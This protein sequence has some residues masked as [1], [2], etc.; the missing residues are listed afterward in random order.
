MSDS[1]SLIRS[2]IIYGIVLPLAIFLGYMLVDLPDMGRSSMVVVGLISAILCAPFLLRWH[3][4]LLFLSW[5]M[6]ALVFFLPGSPEFWIFMALTSF[7]ITITHRALDSNV[8]MFPVPSVIWPLFFILAVVLGTA[9]LTGGI[10]LNSLGGNDV[11]GGRRYL[12]MIAAVLGFLA[13]TSHPIPLAKAPLFAGGFLLGN[14]TNLISNLAPYLGSVIPILFYIFPAD[15]NTFG[16]ISADSSSGDGIARNYGLSYSLCWAFLYVL[17]RYGIKQLLSSGNLKKLT[18]AVL[19]FVGGLV[20][21]F[22]S[23]LLMMLIT[24]FFLFWIEGLFRSRYMLLVMGAFAATLLLLPFAK[25]LPLPIQRAMTVLP[26]VEVD[27]AV[28]REAEGSSEWRIRM[29]KTLL[30][31]VPKYLWLGKGLGINAAEYW[32]EVNLSK[33][34]RGG[35]DAITFMMAGD[36]HNGPLSVIIPFGIWGVLG[37]FWFLAAA[38]RLLYLNQRH[39]DPAL[40]TINR[41]LFAH[42]LA[43]IIIFF[44]VF[45]GF[46]SDFAMFAGIAGLSISLNGGIRKSSPASVRTAKPAPRRLRFPARLAPGH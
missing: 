14:L 28:R 25:S 21:G 32:T 19:L 8:R 4:L 46:Y 38:I 29:W 44:F 41:F 35:E 9:E 11:I 37:W 15:M 2:L 1:T 39:G 6:T 26:V 34:S 22:R 10:H 36:Y 24:G 30:P 16:A 7:F 20:G 18:L 31:E 27:P 17:A 3:H 12:Y 5:N 23:F 43:K 42:F 40:Q 45:G 13:M 33:Q